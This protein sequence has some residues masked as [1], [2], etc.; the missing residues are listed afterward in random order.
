MCIV[1]WSLSVLNSYIRPIDIDR[2][3][4][5]VRSQRI[6]TAF[7]WIVHPVF[8]IVSYLCESVSPN[9]PLSLPETKPQE[10]FPESWVS[11][12]LW[13][14]PSSSII[15]VVIRLKFEINHEVCHVYAMLVC[16]GR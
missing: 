9:Q 12:S 6:E 16:C 8:F 4:D 13:A 7:L 15:Y 2:G 14:S 3:Q 11:A 1:P 10:A 5:C